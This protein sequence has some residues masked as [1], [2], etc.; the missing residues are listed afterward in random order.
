MKPL[1]QKETLKLSTLSPLHL[2]C[3]ESYFPTEY[4]IADQQL[5]LLRPRD[6]QQALSPQQWQKFGNLALQDSP[7]ALRTELDNEKSTLKPFAYRTINL[8][9]GFIQ[10]Q[11][12]RRQKKDSQLEIQR[13]S[14]NPHTEQPFI[15]GSAIKGAI[16]TAILDN[17]N[18]QLELSPAPVPN[19]KGINT[20][21]QNLQHR[22]LAYKEIPEDPLRL[23]KISDSDYAPAE[24]Y[25][26]CNI[27]FAIN[28]KRKPAKKGV[29]SNESGPS[30]I[31]ECLDAGLHQLGQIQWT[32]MN[33]VVHQN[34][35]TKIPKINTLDELCTCVNNYYL[36][37]LKIELDELEALKCSNSRWQQDITSLLEQLAPALKDGHVMLMRLGRYGGADSKTVEG[38]RHIKILGKKGDGAN[39]ESLPHT[40][41]LAGR[42]AKQHENLLPFG[43]VVFERPQRQPL[44]IGELLRNINPHNNAEQA[45]KAQKIEVE[46]QQKR[47]EL[48]AE[49]QQKQQ[50]AQAQIRREKEQVQQRANNLSQLSG[51]GKDI[52]L[53][54]EKLETD[55]N[56]GVGASGQ[57]SADLSQLITKV[58]GEGST[59]ER[60]TLYELATRIY[61]HLGID[62][63][64]NKK[65]KARLKE[66]SSS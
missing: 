27:Y 61:R 53:L 47:A 35:N 18:A 13:T 16:R 8:H 3:D 20:A 49:R 9:E 41:W 66:L 2:G 12:N 4:V 40:R 46:R 55:K 24:E 6:I 28:I 64:K 19:K 33:P 11:N 54:R 17:L 10:Y 48:I 39:Y 15:P 59:E 63:K 26:P 50:A 21:N 1:W 32:L 25:N 37:Q 5:C 62:M 22:L 36:P 45:S 30:N 23:L 65:V 42:N 31:L 52:F 14:Y 58:I 44:E 43:W 34:I 7:T 60:S 56:P 29:Q 57:L 38:C 51:I